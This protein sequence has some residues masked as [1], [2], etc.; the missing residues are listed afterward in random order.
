M[1]GMAGL[2]DGGVRGRD[3]WPEQLGS[4]E[5]PLTAMGKKMKGTIFLGGCRG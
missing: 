5:M 3:F 2:T 4:L 1:I